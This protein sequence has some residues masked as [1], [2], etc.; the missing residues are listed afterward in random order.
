MPD[1]EQPPEWNEEFMYVLA[2]IGK[3]MIAGGEKTGLDKMR[4]FVQ[5][6]E[7]NAEIRVRA[8]CAEIVQ[9]EFDDFTRSQSGSYD[10]G[11]EDA[12]RKIK[13]FLNQKI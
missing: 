7:A 3:N 1:N 13:W 5:K 11:Y 12:L 6:I 8:E 4:A 10:R 2:G 9:R